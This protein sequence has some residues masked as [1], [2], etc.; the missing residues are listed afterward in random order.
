MFD[1]DIGDSFVNIPQVFFGVKRPIFG[2]QSNFCV[3]L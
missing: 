1:R 3:E 2:Y